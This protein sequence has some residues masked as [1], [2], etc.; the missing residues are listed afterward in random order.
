M[1]DDTLPP[2]KPVWT[3][4]ATTHAAGRPAGERS[5]PMPEWVG[6]YRVVKK[7]GSGSM[8]DVYRCHDQ[9]LG[10]EVAVKVLKAQYAVDEH[11]RRRFRREARAVASLSHPCVVQIF[12]IHEG[13]GPEDS[14]YI[15]MEFVDGCSADDFLAENGPVA[16]DLAARWVRDAASGLREAAAKDIIHR[17]V[18]PSNILVTPAGNAKIVDFGL[19]KELGAKNSLTQEGIVLG[20][21][22]Y[23]SPEQGRGRPLDH[24]ADIYSLG[25]TFYHLLTGRPPF[26]GDSQIA[27][28]VAHVNESPVAPHLER[29]EVPESVTRVVFRMMAKS[30]DDR[31]GG[32]DELIEDLDALLAGR[33]PTHAVGVVPPAS[34]AFSRRRLKLVAPLVAALLIGG[35]ALALAPDRRMPP[36]DLSALDTWCVSQDGYRVDLDFDFR[37][38]PD[39]ALKLL[40]RVLTLPAVPAGAERPDLRGSALTW[41]RFSAPF[42]F[43]FAFERLDEAELWIGDTMED[44]DL[45]FSLVSPHGAQNRQLIF[46]LAPRQQREH[47]LLVAIERGREVPPIEIGL[48]GLI[49]PPGSARQ[50]DSL[51]SPVLGAGPFRL[52]FQLEPR[53]D[54]TRVAVTMEK[55]P[56]GSS[57]ARSYRLT[58]VL[59][60]RDWCRGVP[61][62]ATES[63]RD[64]EFSLD[65]AVFRGELAEEFGVTEVPWQR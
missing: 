40:T 62:L 21:P 1:D 16:V 30:P 42:A 6:Q 9:A 44:L 51:G 41:S 37:S 31:Y 36:P 47:P 54:T 20:T 15:V 35:I 56:R 48:T 43:A 24:R 61:T 39:N 45:A 58:A 17:D 26:D 18:K 2:K 55:L 25:A 46:R 50:A 28:I 57:P 19:A 5:A 7:L 12:G 59:P 10:R 34:S 53:G 38:S 49:E 29:P 14:A 3:A 27:V 32:Y 23:I 11:Y 8:G 60:G 64:F 4:A 52:A 33:D 65:R 63:I 13:A 22:H